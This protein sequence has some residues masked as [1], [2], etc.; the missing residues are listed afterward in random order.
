MSQAGPATQPFVGFD[1]A[2]LKVKLKR[3]MP[4]HHPLKENVKYY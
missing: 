2:L 3:A 1:F 4:P